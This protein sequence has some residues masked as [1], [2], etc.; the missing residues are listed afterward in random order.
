ME[1]RLIFYETYPAIMGESTMAGRPGL[2][3]RLSGCNLNCSYCDTRYARG[4]GGHSIST[5]AL[6]DVARKSGLGLVLL[7]GGEPLL[8]RAAP[9]LLAKLDQAGLD[10]MV[11][12][13]GSVILPDLPE[14]TVV[15]MD[16]KSP[17]SGEGESFNEDNLERL[18]PSDEIKM[19]LAG[20]EDYLWA[21]RAIRERELAGRW[22]VILSPA[23][24]RL[25]P[26]KLG[27]WI[28]KDRLRARLGLQLHKLIYPPDARRV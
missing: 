21:R 22:T 18:R 17:G 20:R 13:N 26:A 12:T 19:V 10:T 8:Q 25:D 28:L 11:E 23:H 1:D 5:G 7:T 2:I 16:I 6:A 9:L 27:E 24:G 3:I 15:V 14:S 4:R